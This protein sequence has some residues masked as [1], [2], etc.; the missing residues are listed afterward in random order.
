MGILDTARDWKVAP[1]AQVGGSALL[2]GGGVYWL[3]FDSETAGISETFM[4]IGGGLGIG[5]SVG[6]VSLSPNSPVEIECERAFSVADLNMSPGR[7]DMAGASLAAGYGF[8]WISAF[9]LKGFMLFSS[10]YVGGWNAGVALNAQ[11]IVGYWRSMA[12]AG[13]DASESLKGYRYR[14]SLRDPLIC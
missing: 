1:A 11:T 7:L 14:Y 2:V 9:T 5:G 13:R 8:M 6:A 10:Q 4:F 3:T 12:L